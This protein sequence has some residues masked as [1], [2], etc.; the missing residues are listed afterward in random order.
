LRKKSDFDEEW[1]W[2][3]VLPRKRVEEGDGMSIFRV[4][5]AKPMFLL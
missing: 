2:V 5:T 1:E 3:R 4:F